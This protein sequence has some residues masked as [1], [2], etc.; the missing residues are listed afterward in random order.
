M[1]SWLRV[2]GLGLLKWPAKLAALVVVPFLN[3][4]QRNDHPVFGVRDAVDLSYWNIA[5]RNSVHNM[6]TIDQPNYRWY[7]NTD[8][9]DMEQDG[10]Q[11][12][13]CESFDGQYV[14]FRITW[15][16]ARAKGKREFYVGWTMNQ[17]SYARLTFFQFRPF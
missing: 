11:W 12:R 10:F 4:E 3:E 2:I 15:G 9:F 1:R 7:G 17:K 13:R 5:V 16:K 6:I 8:D 14:S